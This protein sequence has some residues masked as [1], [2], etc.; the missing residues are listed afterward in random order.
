MFL[1]QTCSRKKYEYQ[2]SI[3]EKLLSLISDPTHFWKYLKS[4]QKIKMC[5]NN[6]SVEQW[7]Q[8]FK[9]LFESKDINPNDHSL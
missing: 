1:K 4:I 7:R 6:I 2:R 9:S 8:Y 5:E 3:Q